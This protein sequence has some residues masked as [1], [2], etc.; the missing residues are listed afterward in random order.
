M[1]QNLDNMFDY[2]GIKERNVN[3]PW[4]V[5]GGFAAFGVFALATV[6]VRVTT[7]WLLIDIH[8][9]H[10]PPAHATEDVAAS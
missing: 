5:K 8:N 3:L 7:Y 10:L 6:A 2:I 1:L 4:V 9:L